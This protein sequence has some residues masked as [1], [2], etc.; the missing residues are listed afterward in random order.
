[1]SN[2]LSSHSGVLNPVDYGAKGDNS[3]D[4]T[5]SLIDCFAAAYSQRKIVF[6]P[7]G[8]YIISGTVDAPVP[9][10]GVS[11]FMDRESRT[12]SEWNTIIKND[13]SIND[14]SAMFRVSRTL[15]P[16]VAPG[17]WC[18][19]IKFDGGLYNC[20]GI[21]GRD[22]NWDEEVMHNYYLYRVYAEQCAIGLDFYGFL[23]FFNDCY[24]KRNTEIG[25]RMTRNNAGMVTG[26]E[27]AG[28][29]SGQTG[30][31]IP[32]IPWSMVINA[33]GLVDTTPLHGDATKTGKSN[34]GSG[35][36]TLDG[37]TIEAQDMNNGLQISEGFNTVLLNNI[38]M[39]GYEGDGDTETFSL[40]IGNVN[41]WGDGAATDDLKEAISNVII[42]NIK[43]GNGAGSWD[44]PTGAT[45]GGQVKYGN[46][47]NL[48]MR[49]VTN[50][51][52]R[53]IFSDKCLFTS[54]DY[55][56]GGLRYGYFSNNKSFGS[57]QNVVEESAAPGNGPINF[58][59]NSNFKGGIRGFDNVILQ[60]TLE[61]AE[62]IAITRDGTSSLEIRLPSGGNNGSRMLLY[63][64][65]Q[66]ELSKG[67]IV[68]WKLWYY[69]PNLTEY[70][71]DTAYPKFGIRYNTPTPVTEEESTI[72]P[73]SSD[74][75]KNYTIGKWNLAHSFAEVPSGATDIHLSIQPVTAGTVPA[76]Y[77][78]YIS[79]FAMVLHP[80]A[81]HR[82]WKGDYKLHPKAGNFVGDALHTY[83]SV[84]P[85]TSDIQALKGD[86]H[87]N[88]D[89]DSGG[90][91]YIGWVC[92][93]SGAPGTWS[94]FGNIT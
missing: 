68:M 22:D 51:A 39:E 82:F 75:G 40:S 17:W 1:M 3:R 5:Q 78:I 36:I 43:Y 20:I 92:T 67:G 59:V 41:R 9:F 24:C 38:Y 33:S 30:Y 87:W 69:V 29:Q 73:W 45:I 66:D 35:V 15:Y 53:V 85:S 77:Y 64:L 81:L 32:P 79:D 83:G 52:K 6:I 19:D 54:K 60:N 94:T 16:D 50:S 46:I 62:E 13:G 42:D 18:K 55:I 90:S 4:D 12:A 58:I 74:Y 56:G 10:Y 25:L 71:N 80:G 2:I 37:T 28:M 27:Y 88:T 76:D 8:N 23:G 70:A 63:P 48:D 34:K 14:G 11:G 72:T 86:I 21:Q 93:G 61:A 89:P 91:E 26:G 47:V 49:N 7:R 44:T 31:G 84:E 65:G 57:A